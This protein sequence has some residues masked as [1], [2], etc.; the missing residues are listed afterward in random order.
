MSH[1]LATQK[2]I[3]QI[4]ERT[5]ANLK[6]SLAHTSNM[7]GATLNTIDESI[8]FIARLPLSIMRFKAPVCRLEIK[9]NEKNK[10][11]EKISKFQTKRN[12]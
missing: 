6:Q 1:N 11:K 12:V 5:V 3:S 9:S 7:V 10:R 8:K 4:S 2:Y